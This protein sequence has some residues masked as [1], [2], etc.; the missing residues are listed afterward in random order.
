M[1]DMK[2]RR[3]ISVAA[4]GA[5]LLVL[6]SF[7]TAQVAEP[8]PRL[9]PGS[10]LGATRAAPPLRAATL[11]THYPGGRTHSPLTPIVAERLR[12]LAGR[13]RHH[14]SIFAKIGASASRSRHFMNCF[15][16]DAVDLASHQEL[17]ETWHF[18]RDGGPL[19]PFA[20][21]SHAT[22]EGW[23]AGRALHGG[24][25][26]TMRE[27]Q[28][29]NPRFAVIMFGTNDIEHGR[30]DHYAR[31]MNRLVETLTARGVIPVMTT[32]MPRDDRVSADQVVDLYN[33]VVRGVAQRHQVPLVDF[34]RE[35]AQ[36]PDHGLSR[37]G[38]HPNVHFVSGRARGCDLGEE[39]LQHG[40]NIRNLITL[41]ALDRLRRV[42]LT[43][44]APPDPQDTSL[45][46]NGSSAHPFEIDALPFAHSSNTTLSPHDRVDRYPAC[47]EHDQS[48][49]EVVYRIHLDE[50]ARIHAMV[51]DDD[52]TD[53]DV[54]VL[55]EGRC[56]A[57]G[58]ERVE[59]DLP[60]GTHDIAIDTFVD[61][62]QPRGGEYL[63]V[64]ARVDTPAD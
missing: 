63:F 39:G 46:G 9:G 18:F 29:I 52:D 48:G 14:A 33:T 55:N 56:A 64:V 51:V 44:E 49:P 12:G 6:G 34:H 54:H 10:P 50:P 35:L 2:V 61:D 62:G 42:V 31:R 19:N 60:A 11:G 25:S 20:R 27:L 24:N 3:V 53:V 22:V 5:T 21:R 13:G 47:G 37:D 41:Q 28:S 36:L 45:R 23:Q 58:D 59:L 16:S 15:A 1:K 17:R 4:A 8:S 32:I 7:A 26:P 38:V 30:P 57:R 43:N 40:Y